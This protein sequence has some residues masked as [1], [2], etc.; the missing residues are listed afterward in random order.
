[1]VNK[2]VKKEI[3]KYSEAKE[4]DNTTAPNLWTTAKVV[5]RGKYIAIQAFL[6]KEE[7]SQIHNLTLHLKKM[8]KERHIK[9]KTAE[10]RK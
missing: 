4:N 7:R 6:R 8:E 10:D 5:I 3:E 1:M 9:P 2:E